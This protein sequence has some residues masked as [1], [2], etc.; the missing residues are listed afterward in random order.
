MTEPRILPAAPPYEPAVAKAFDAFTAGREPIKLF[1]TMAR[2]P[3]LLG[4]FFAGSLLDPGSISIAE[5]EIMI[6]RTTA[7]CG[8]EY[9]WGVH[10]KIF[11]ARAGLTPAQIAASAQGTAED[12][13]WSPNQRL[14]IRLAD[15]LHDTA[16]VPE[17]LWS[18]LAA[19]WRPDQLLEL[20]VLAGNYHMVAFVTNSL[21]VE[22]EDFAAR[23]PAAADEPRRRPELPGEKYGA[24]NL[25]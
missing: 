1:R 6:L 23:F 7:R 13:A 14:L 2:N 19:V 9:E 8:S 11:A 18:A 16:T 12:P 24:L 5:R 15:V 20:I 3:R 17:D 25:D 21:G 22:L 4:R 10:V